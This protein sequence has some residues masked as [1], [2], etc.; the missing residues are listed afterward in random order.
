MA[1]RTNASKGRSAGTYKNAGSASRSART[2]RFV[3]KT[4]H[5]HAGSRQTVAESP[6]SKPSTSSNG[7][8]SVRSSAASK[9]S[10][11][12]QSRQAIVRDAKTLIAKMDK[13]IE[14]LPKGI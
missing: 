2:G 13:N 10:F 5:R 9:A 3:S 1:K 6:S 11:T 7:M 12:I 4:S 14:R 8:K